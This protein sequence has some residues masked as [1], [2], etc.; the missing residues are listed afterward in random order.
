MNRR[1]LRGFPLAVVGLTFATLRALPATDATGPAATPALATP[2]GGEVVIDEEP[3]RASPCDVDPHFSIRVPGESVDPGFVVPVPP[4][5]AWADVDPHFSVRI[6]CNSAAD[7]GR[8]PEAATPA[9]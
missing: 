7:R 2:A 4:D 6:P 3:P 8:V 5:S 9:P 1:L